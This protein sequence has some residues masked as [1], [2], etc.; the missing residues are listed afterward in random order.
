MRRYDTLHPNDI[1][2]YRKRSKMA[3]NGIDVLLQHLSSILDCNNIESKYTTIS[4]HLG[5]SDDGTSRY[6]YFVPLN[7]DVVFLLRLSNH[8][9]TNEM[10]YNKFEQMGRP[11]ARYIIYFKGNDPIERSSEVWL[12]SQHNV[13]SYPV[14]A[15]DTSDNIKAF[16]ITLKKLFTN[17]EVDFPVLPQQTAKNNTN[18][19]NNKQI[20][21]NIGVKT[22]KKTIRL[23]ESDLHQIIKESVNNI[24]NLYY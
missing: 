7:K 11:D 24:L 18:L 4:A 19:T 9:N 13:I 16:L 15:L 14:N 3:I 10:L 20:N 23:T 5:L 22:N 12:E 1:I 2:K 17:G 8:N 21:C 6:N